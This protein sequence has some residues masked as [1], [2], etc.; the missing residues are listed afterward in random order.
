[1]HQLLWHLGSW[2]AIIQGMK[3]RNKGKLERKLVRF[4]MGLTRMLEVRA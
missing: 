3:T 1:M 4:D 2:A